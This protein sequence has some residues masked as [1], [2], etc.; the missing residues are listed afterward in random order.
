MYEYTHRTTTDPTVGERFIARPQ[1]D[2]A[3][4]SEYDMV[5][6]SPEFTRLDEHLISDSVSPRSNWK[7]CEHYKCSHVPQSGSS[8][9]EVTIEHGTNAWLHRGVLK[10]P[11][12]F[13]KGTH[14]PAGKYN[15]GLPQFYAPR[16]DGGFI[17]PPA[18]LDSLLQTSLNAMLPRIKAELSI[19]N[20]LIELKDF[21]TMRKTIESVLARAT[22][23]EFSHLRS[24][25]RLTDLF[26]TKADVYLQYK[27]NIAPLL[28]DISGIYRSLANTERRINDFI[29]RSGRVRV[30][31]FTRSLTELSE[32]ESSIQTDGAYVAFDYMSG[33]PYNLYSQYQSQ[34][35]TSTEPAS[36]HVQLQY[37]YNYTQYQLEHARVLALLDSLGLNLNPAIIWNALPW[38]F[39][40]DWVLGVNR[41]LT[42]TNVRNMDPK[43][44]ILRC[45]WSVRRSRRIQ[46][47]GKVTSNLNISDPTL[48]IQASHASPVVVESA[49][50]RQV[51]NP[52][53]SSIISSG[54]N[55]SEFTLGAAL[56][57]SQRRRPKRLRQ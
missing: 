5:I 15:L 37:N 17:P 32:T 36:F 27:F 39:V 41:Y 38:S 57:I 9:T 46:V 26:R 48:K 34:R 6:S 18:D 51:F 25:R 47:L 13:D 16:A 10:N 28:S 31:H 43:I 35:F 50:R 22:K 53:S 1:V 54:L 23:F 2:S 7:S 42:S 45:L 20:S 8:G 3:N 49:Y 30:S 56:I 52:S 19:V 55:S 4:Q 40:V 33:T 11:S 12:V 44:N 14:G 24:S 21:L 29:T